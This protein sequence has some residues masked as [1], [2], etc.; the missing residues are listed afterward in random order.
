[1]GQS[2]LCVCHGLCGFCIHR[3]AHHQENALTFS[4]KEPAD[5]KED[6]KERKTMANIKRLTS[7]RVKG[8]TNILQLGKSIQV[9]TLFGTEP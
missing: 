3:R 9:L 8:C 5:V 4:G 1:M 2:M 6:V 7:S